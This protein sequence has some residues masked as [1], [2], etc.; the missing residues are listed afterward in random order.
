MGGAVAQRGRQ[1]LVSRRVSQF[2]CR[3]GC[4]LILLNRAESQYHI[5]NKTK[6]Q[7]QYTPSIEITFGLRLLRYRRKDIISNKASS[8]AP[9]PAIPAMTPVDKFER[10][11]TGSTDEFPENHS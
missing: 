11:G 10:D 4:R 1:Q 3:F 6:N 2:E 9:P 5:P 7:R 8:I